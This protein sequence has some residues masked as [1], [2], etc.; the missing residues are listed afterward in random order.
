MKAR[1]LI[2]SFNYAF[3]GVI[4]T[5]KTQRNMRLHF[6]AT[7]VVL[8]LS[9]LLRL[10]KIEILILFITIAIV[11]ITEMINTAVEVTVDLVTQEYHPMAAIAKNVAAGAVLV[12]SVLAIIVGYLI[13][14]PKFNSRIPLVIITLQKA[15]AYLSMIALTL[16]IV[17][18]IVGKS[19]TKKGKPVQGGM[20]SGHVALSTVAASTIAF[21]TKNALMALLAFFLVLLV[22]ESRIENKVHSL[23]EV[24][25]GGIL[26]FLVTWLIFQ[27]MR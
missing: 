19:I 22:A 27:L 14:F 12:T 2:D 6:L 8:I 25:A 26:G 18:V 17:L 1:S 5:F 16:T 4:H 7:A 11:I 24:I 3:D 13:F 9:L 15:P 20:P 23:A 10:T 21:T